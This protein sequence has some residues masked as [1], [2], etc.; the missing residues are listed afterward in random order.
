V[1][2]DRALVV[3]L[4]EQAQAA[5][6]A[7]PVEMFGEALE[8]A[9]RH[10]FPA[11]PSVPECRSFLEALRLEDL[12]L[13]RA[14]AA[15]NDAAWEFFIR[16]HRPAL[17]RAAEAI[18]RTGG[19]RELADSLYA[20][21]FGLR[22]RDGQ[23]HSL[24]TYFHGRSSIG[25]WVRAVLSQRYIDL[26]RARRR[27]DPLPDDESP[28]ALPAPA[29]DRDP[30]RDRLRTVLHEALR[31]VL[32]LLVPRDRLRLS[33]YYAQNL[34][35]AAIG[36][37]LGEHEATISRHLTRTR[38]DIRVAV[39][40]R[41]RDEHGLTAAMISEC[42]TAAVDDSGGLDLTTLLGAVAAGKNP[43]QD[44]S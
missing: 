8:A 17:Y 42:F 31:A 18:D 30:A 11:E 9:I 15:G 14:C 36:R 7:L 40:Q 2:V 39:E 16:E 43:A 33:C 20:D 10:A 3:R 26:L 44:R 29:V 4:H 1:P 28:D 41:L 12:A 5:R 37:L 38:R 25:S 19:G 24:F 23:R 32:G 27:L 21:L 13:A 6:W 34:K 35:L 22:E